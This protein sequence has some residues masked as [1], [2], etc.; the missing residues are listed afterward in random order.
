MIYENIRRIAKEQGYSIR[1]IEKALFF[2]NGYLRRW[3]DNAPVNKLLRV[4]DFLGVDL[5]DLLGRKN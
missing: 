5:N 1:D 3:K 2:S 4:A